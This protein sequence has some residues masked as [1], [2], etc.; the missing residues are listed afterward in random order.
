VKSEGGRVNHKDLEVWKHSTVLAKTA[1]K[2]CADFPPSELHGLSS[3]MRRSAVSIPS[4]I[5][6]GAARGTDKE[7]VHFPHIVPGS[8]AELDTQYILSKEFQF[9]Q[10]CEEVEKY[11][12][13]VRKMTLGLI[14]HLK[15]SG[16]AKSEE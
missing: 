15:N 12:E 4:N 5:T 11:I 3:Q 7:L 16:T 13:N 6:E 9:T 1:Y 8:L 10:A 2:L 14:K